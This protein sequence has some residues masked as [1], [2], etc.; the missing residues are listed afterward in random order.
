[1]QK[2]ALYLRLSREDEERKNE[3]QS[4]LNQRAFLLR[5]AEENKFEIYDIYIDDGF[6]GT[7]FDRPGF[8]RMIADIE[9]GL[10]QIVLV[11]DLSR[12]GRDHIDTGY[13][14]ERYFPTR[15]VR[16]IAV[17]DGIDTE[18]ETV[19][20]DMGLFKAAFNDFY[21]KDI[22]KK[23]I[24]ALQAKKKN[25]EFIGAIAPYGYQKSLEFK[26]KLI[27]NPEEAEI[28]HCIFERRLQGN[29]FTAIA[30]WLNDKKIPP[31]SAKLGN[32]TACWSD[33]VVKR[34]LTNPTY[35]GDLTQNRSRKVNYKVSRRRILPAEEWITVQNTHA[36]LVSRT[37][38]EQVQARINSSQ[39]KK[40]VHPLGGLLFCASCGN[41]MTF[42]YRNGYSYAV[43]AGW[44][45]SGGKFCRSHCCREDAL[46]RAIREWIEIKTQENFCCIP[47]EFNDNVLLFENVVKRV[48]LNEKKEVILYLKTGFET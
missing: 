6:T 17:N 31:P 42:V 3:S 36:P 32:K 44:K 29:G 30:R 45:R 41:K 48:E 14:Y 37:L 4:I 20:N 7:N 1:M 21:A 19:G 23:V 16:F 10:I 11:K 46:N 40:G 47:K 26:N 28:V 9:K 12:L 8:R 35:C 43:C 39:S 13:Y 33:T 15:N 27:P 25:G 22:S 24:S 18:R 5:Y 2:T 34:I 38:F